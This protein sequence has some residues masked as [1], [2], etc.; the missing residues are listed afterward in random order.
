MDDTAKPLSSSFTTEFDIA[1]KSDPQQLKVHNKE[2]VNRDLITRDSIRDNS[3]SAVLHR[4]HYGTYSGRPACLV[5][6]DFSFSF[7]PKVAARY[8]HATITATFRRAIDKKRPKIISK[9]PSGDPKVVNFAPK[10]VYGFVKTVEDKAIRDLSIPVMFESPVGVSLGFEGHL[11]LERTEHQDNRMEIYGSFQTA[12]DHSEGAI[13]VE[14]K[15]EE[16]RTQCDGIFR[17]FRTAIVLINPPEQPMWMSVEVKPSVK[18]SVNPEHL[19]KKTDPWAR[20]FQLSDDPV[21]L[22]GKTSKGDSS[23]LGSH[24]LSSKE[25]PWSKFLWLPVE[26]Q[27]SRVTFVASIH[28]FIYSSC[29][30]TPSLFCCC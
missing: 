26:Y 12:D 2:V 11:G 16:N 19:F 13:G 9:D 6:I 14:W 18:F 30:L 17:D 10:E 4:V 20:L 29:R 8:S 1:T 25:F 3:F 28:S 22:D 24:D 15:L 5:S 23:Q 27:A 7:R 21:L